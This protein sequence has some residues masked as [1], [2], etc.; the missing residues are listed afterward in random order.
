MT[1]IGKR[2]R[3]TLHVL[4]SVVH[5]AS[6]RRD[7]D[8]IARRLDDR[9]AADSAANLVWLPVAL[10]LYGEPLPPGIRSSW[11]FV[12]RA[13]TASGA[14]RHPNSIQRVMS[15]RGSADLQTKPD[16]EWISNPL[17]SRPDAPLEKRWLSIPAGVWHQG[18]MGD[19][20][21]VVVSFHTVFPEG[22]VEERP[23]PEGDRTTQR[24]YVG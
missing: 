7:L 20:N 23:A 3:E 14:E 22:L 11:V 6:V 2:E 9:L 8:A 21:W 13:N 15:Y 19:E 12:L 24:Y 16:N 4:D 10:S 18:V 5:A 1:P 17:V